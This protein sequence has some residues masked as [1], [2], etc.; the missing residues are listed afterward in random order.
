MFLEI[1]ILSILYFYA[2][3][4]YYFIFP[5]PKFIVIEG[6]IGAGKS[7]FI[8]ILKS[9]LEKRN[10][11]VSVVKEPVDKWV[12]NGILKVFYQDPKRWAY[13]FQAQAFHDR[14]QEIIKGFTESTDIVIAERSPYSD[15][16]FMNVA[17]ENKHV[18]DM[19]FNLYQDWWSMWMKLIPKTPDLVIYLRTDLNNC[20]KRIKI[21]HRDGESGISEDYERQLQEQ[22]ESTFK[23]SSNV[24]ILNGGLNFKD[25]TAVQ[26]ELVNKVVERLI[27]LG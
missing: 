22:H 26:K 16:L 1:V 20:M 19:E 7:T 9:Y 2:D 12:S 21:R 6:L 23:E 5:K 25:D 3:K 15:R 10:Q 27:Q 14:I 8:P 17:R 11:R 13:T 24:L 4:I 18:S